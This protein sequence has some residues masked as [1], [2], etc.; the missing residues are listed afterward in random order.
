MDLGFAKMRGY[1]FWPAK[2]MGE[3]KNKLWVKFY[4]CDQMGAVNNNDKHWMPI[5]SD[6]FRKM[7]N[8]KTLKRP[9]YLKAVTE[10]ANVIKENA[11]DGDLVN[12]ISEFEQ[13]YLKSIPST[14]ASSVGVTAVLMTA[15]DEVDDMKSATG[16]VSMPAIPI[17][18]VGQIDLL[19]RYEEVDDSSIFD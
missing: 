1:S 3:V 16:K 5:N 4:G 14:P 7:V 8:P 13:L 10:I 12:N 19:L 15:E 11:S 17:M 6:I 18:V 2:K 9:S